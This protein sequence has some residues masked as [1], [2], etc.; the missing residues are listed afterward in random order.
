MRTYCTKNSLLTAT[1]MAALG[2]SAFLL[3]GCGRAETGSSANGAGAGSGDVA[4]VVFTEREVEASCGLCQFEM[5]SPTCELAIRTDGKT[6]W[7]DGVGID[8][9]GDAHAEDGLCNVIRH[10]HITG[11]LANGR[12]NAVTVKLLDAHAE[13]DG[14][15]H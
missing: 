5:D 14:H 13:G 11:S 15:E 1:M 2:V 4:P 12:F 8:D 7:V 10:A 6:Y 9:L 3:S